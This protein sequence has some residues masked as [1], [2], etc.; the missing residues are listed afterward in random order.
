MSDRDREIPAEG[1]G[2]NEGDRVS[3]TLLVRPTMSIVV[4]KGPDVGKSA[5]FDQARITVGRHAS[6][7]FSIQD[8][9]VSKHHGEFIRSAYGFTFRDLNSRY[10]SL[11]G[12]DIDQMAQSQKAMDPS[13]FISDHGTIQ[14]GITLLRVNVDREPCSASERDTLK[15]K[16]EEDEP[17]EQVLVSKSTSITEDLAKQ[18]GQLEVLFE[19]SKQLNG[20]NRLDQI[21]DRVVDASFKCFD[22]ASIFSISLVKE[23]VLRPFL[24]RAS[25]AATPGDAGQIV[26]SQSILN[27]VM[28]TE[29]A[30]LFIRGLGESGETASILDARIS[31][32]M[33]AP[34]V[35]QRKLLGVMQI[36]TREFGLQFS[37]SDLNLFSVFA[38]H[39]AFALERAGLTE[40]IY[41]MFE[42]FVQASVTAI[43]ARDPIT[44]GHSSRV[45]K[46]AVALAE[47]MVREENGGPN[48]P[49]LTQRDLT[50]LRYAALLHDFGKVGV[51]EAVLMKGAR[52]PLEHQKEI[53]QRFNRIKALYRW[54]MDERLLHDSVCTGSPVRPDQLRENEEKIARFEAEL[55]DQK[56]FLIGIQKMESLS[57]EEIDR[58]KELGKRSID[59]GGGEMLR[60]LKHDEVENLTIPVGTLN[61]R[62]W[63][64]MCSH[65]SRSEEFLKQIPWSDDLQ[66]VPAIAAG[67]HEKLNG[68]GYPRGLRSDQIPLIVRVLTI[69]DV[70]DALT[71]W[72][73]PHQRAR[74]VAQ[75]C[76]ILRREAANHCLDADLV[77]LFVCRIVPKMESDQ[78]R[79][80][81]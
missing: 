53:E 51:R 45:A 6:N 79:K 72:D 17:A 50:Q 2:L 44:A 43:E 46:M 19:L 78:N 54:K 34:L 49:K 31:A 73:R 8:G 58:V 76:E 22:G 10:G 75:A 80:Q 59:A 74:S 57:Q 25:G 38:S 63:R 64:D 36:D 7:D 47:E 41:R 29:E 40:D 69:A 21:L 39:V 9:F 70:F 32:S 42:G 77:E 14:L 28:E 24:V 35:G 66:L 30:V 33:C 16:I 11:V 27:R 56:K 18:D 81:S 67:H 12:D 3:D 65:V 48:G 1:A 26:V 52:L 15:L 37:Q 4:E 23:G 68:S 20:L 13:V 71:A 5:R 62:E 55:E 61:E 60:Y